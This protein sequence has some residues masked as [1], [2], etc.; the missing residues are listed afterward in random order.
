MLQSKDC[1]IILTWSH[2][3]S[4]IYITARL[5]LRQ[6]EIHFI[7]ENND[8][9]LNSRNLCFD[10]CFCVLQIF[11]SFNSFTI[12]WTENKKQRKWCNACNLNLLTVSKIH[13][14][15]REKVPSNKTPALTKS[16]NMG[17][18]VV[19]SIRSTVYKTFLNRNKIFKK[20]K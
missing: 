13:R 16:R 9:N 1:F 7:N 2:I 10:F 3:V 19:S 5:N 18:W 14:M 6:P 20:I 17:I 11:F 8:K 15:K 12:T 4:L